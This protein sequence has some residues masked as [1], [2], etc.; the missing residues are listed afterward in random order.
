MKNPAGWMS[1]FHA[2]Q[3]REPGAD[4]LPPD[5]MRAEFSR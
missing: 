4:D 5:F 2:L 3:T 1:G